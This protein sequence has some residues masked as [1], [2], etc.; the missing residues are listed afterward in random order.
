VGTPHV[1]VDQYFC[2][3]CASSFS[4]PTISHS[5]RL[6]RPESKVSIPYLP[7]MR[8]SLVEGSSER[9]T[10]AVH[11]HRVDTILSCSDESRKSKIMA[12]AKLTTTAEKSDDK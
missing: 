12:Y 2:P 6:E 11:I 10:K 7:Y 9:Y 1:F 5:C 4:V 8:T 3:S